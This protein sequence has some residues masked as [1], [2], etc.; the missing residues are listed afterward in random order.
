MNKTDLEQIGTL[1]E[2][3]L[4]PIKDILDEHTRKLDGIVNQLA[5]VSEDVSDIKEKVTFHEKRISKVE[6]HLG[7]PI[8]E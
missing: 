7:L 5:D 1:I 8:T 3:K 4:E 6:D 2:E